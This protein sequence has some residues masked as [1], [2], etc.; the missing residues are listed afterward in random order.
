MN[1]DLL[2]AYLDGELSG[3]EH[4]DMTKALAADDELA[5][6]HG[7]LAQVRALLRGD[8]V[9]VPD[10]A[11]ERMISAV[12]VDDV[13]ASA[14][15]IAP[16]VAL[17]SRGGVPMFAAVAAALAVIAGVVG[18]LGGSTQIPALGDLI[19]QHEV[20]AAV[21]DG[22]PMPDEMGELHSMPMDEASAAAPPMPKDYSMAQ[23]F[24]DG[25][26]L[27]LVY[28][29]GHGEPVSVIRQEGDADLAALGE[30]SMVSADGAEMWSAPMDDAYVAVVDSAGY[31]WIVISAEPDDDMMDEMMHDLPSRSLS[32]EERLRDAADALVAPFRL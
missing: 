22:A 14:G 1:E 21:V 25:S 15:A 11:V 7:D 3:A 10:G 18:G 6:I 12:E 16:V 26:T 5:A 20:A 2:S 29:T 4:E 9:V 24:A 17:P 8:A 27:H 19:A 32:W 28:R 23:A 30:G 31:I 13:D